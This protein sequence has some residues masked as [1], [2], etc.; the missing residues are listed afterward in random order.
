MLLALSINIISSF[1]SENVKGCKK[2]SVADPDPG[3]KIVSKMY[4]LIR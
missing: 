2:F 1:A 3:G 4:R